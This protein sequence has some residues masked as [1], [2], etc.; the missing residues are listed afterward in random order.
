MFKKFQDG[1]FYGNFPSQFCCVFLQLAE[2][3]QV[4]RA[5]GKVR[6]L[7]GWG[8]WGVSV[9]TGSHCQVI[10]E[11]KDWK[12]TDRGD[13]KSPVETWKVGPRFVVKCVSTIFRFFSDVADVNSI[14]RGEKPP[15]IQ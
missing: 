10:G 11:D 7:W 5:K 14:Y 8:L 4:F 9:R 3:A 15:V 6:G 2:P 13:N 12:R 1:N